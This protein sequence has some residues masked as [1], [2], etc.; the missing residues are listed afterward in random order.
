MARLERLAE[1]DS[2][3]EQ[4]TRPLN[5]LFLTEDEEYFGETAGELLEHGFYSVGSDFHDAFLA[6]DSIGFHIILADVSREPTIP[7]PP[8]IAVNA[9]H[10]PVE[11]PPSDLEEEEDIPEVVVDEGPYN[12]QALFTDLRNRKDNVRIVAMSPEYA[13]LGPEDIVKTAVGMGAEAVVGLPI[14]PEKTAALFTM[15]LD[16]SIEEEDDAKDGFYETK[17]KGG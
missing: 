15:L 16:T 4:N 14:D 12:F 11:R 10:P 7:E 6:Y 17:P 13:D 8:E 1:K 9:T 2:Q 3:R 5:V